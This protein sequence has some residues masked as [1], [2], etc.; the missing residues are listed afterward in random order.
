[1]PRSPY[2]YD[3][4]GNIADLILQGGDIAARR[5][6]SSGDIW[7][8]AFSNIGQQLG[9]VVNQYFQDREAQKKKEEEERKLTVQARAVN[10][11]ID[12]GDVKSLFKILPPD[13]AAI[14][15]K[16]LETHRPDALKTYG[17]KMA[18]LRD[19]AR[20]VEALPEGSRSNGQAASIQSFVAN[21]VLS[22]EEGQ[23]Y[24]QYNPDLNKRLA[25]WGEKPQEAKT[26]GFT[27]GEGQ[28]RFDAAGNIIAKGAEKAEK[29]EK[30]E[31]PL[32]QRVAEAEAMA[33]ASARG[34]AS[35]KP[36][37]APK[38]STPEERKALTFYEQGASALKDYDALG[39]IGYVNTGV[40]GT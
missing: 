9:G 17:D 22:P 34:T 11:A 18:L 31:K 35:G 29:A 21:G 28:T 27:L 4:G 30:P 15:A 19:A 1:M 38:P 26:E 2:G 3:S 16:S 7:G 39:D 8:N 5:A 32:A 36:A 13:K 20:G 12:S 14:V 24:G 10:D 6:L 33:A 25:N 23:R 40:V 37:E